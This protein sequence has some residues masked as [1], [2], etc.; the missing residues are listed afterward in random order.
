M[1]ANPK[2]KICG[3]HQWETVHFDCVEVAL[4][5]AMEKPIDILAKY[6]EDNPAEIYFHYA[7][8]VPIVVM[9]EEKYKEMR[10]TIDDASWDVPPPPK[11]EM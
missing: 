4:E 10:K 1:S 2:C 11:P 3:K 7:S 9:T 6:F 8:K 5:R